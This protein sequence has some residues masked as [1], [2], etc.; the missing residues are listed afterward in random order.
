MW[1]YTRLLQW[2]IHTMCM[3]WHAVLHHSSNCHHGPDSKQF[4]TSLSYD[5]TLRLKHEWKTM[6]GEMGKSVHLCRSL[7]M[8]SSSWKPASTGAAHAQA[9]FHARKKMHKNNGAPKMAS[10]VT[11][12]W[13]FI[14]T[15]PPH[16]FNVQ[17]LFYS[18]RNLF[19]GCKCIGNREPCIW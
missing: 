18:I 13:R 16:F 3:W 1:Y 12:E 2:T 17:S 14:Y 11:S 10:G 8:Q 5:Q 19:S 6:R 7:P 9:A 4:F 15:Y